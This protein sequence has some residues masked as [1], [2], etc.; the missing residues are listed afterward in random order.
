MRRWT[1]RERE[2]IG[3]Q[4]EKEGRGKMDV[5]GIRRVVTSWREEVNLATTALTN[6]IT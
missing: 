5:G 1:R 6:P 3:D 2:K 4:F